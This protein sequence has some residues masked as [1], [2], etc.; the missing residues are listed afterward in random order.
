MLETQQEVTHST[1]P[2]LIHTQWSPRVAWDASAAGIPRIHSLP[3]HS[4]DLTHVADCPKC[5]ILTDEKRCTVIRTPC[6]RGN[7][8]KEGT[9][10]QWDRKCMRDTAS[11]AKFAA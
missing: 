2:L 4:T 11:L 10:V 3:Q 8:T 5:P 1:N 7:K 6:S 9:E